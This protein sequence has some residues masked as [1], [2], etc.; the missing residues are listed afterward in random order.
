D[1]CDQPRCWY[2]DPR[3]LALSSAGTH[4]VIGQVRPSTEADHVAI[5]SFLCDIFGQSEEFPSVQADQVRW[6]FSVP[7]G[8]YKGDRSWV[9][10]HNGEII[11]HGGVWP[12]WILTVGGEAAGLHVIDWAGKLGAAGAGA[13]LMRQ[14]G[15]LGTFTCAAGGSKDTEKILPLLGFRVAHQ[16]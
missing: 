11:A 10:E 16:L 1:S 7:R 14:L 15:R 6:K 2:R 12:L 4:G 8:D 5:V 13:F 9:I 3:R